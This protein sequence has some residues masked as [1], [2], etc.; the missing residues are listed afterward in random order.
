MQAAS[1]DQPDLRSRAT[2]MLRRT[3]NVKREF[4]TARYWILIND[5]R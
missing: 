2:Y 3:I 4:C 1:L 5:F